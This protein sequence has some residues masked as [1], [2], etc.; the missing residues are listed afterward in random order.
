MC[1]RKET[2]YSV[3]RDLLQC[4][5]RPTACQHGCVRVLTP[6]LKRQVAQF[7]DVSAGT[8]DPSLMFVMGGALLLNIPFMQLLIIPKRMYVFPPPPPGLR[9]SRVQEFPHDPKLP[10]SQRSRVHRGDRAA[11]FAL[12]IS[13]DTCPLLLSRWTPVPSPRRLSPATS[14]QACTGTAPVLVI[15]M[16]SGF[17]DLG[18]TSVPAVQQRTHA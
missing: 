15:G 3:K 14:R 6:A 1:V 8:W 10:L 2:Y 12:A 4:Q 5:K 11:R 9:D 17:T 7:L 13:L 18:P 16:P